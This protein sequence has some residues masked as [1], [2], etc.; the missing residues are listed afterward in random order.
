MEFDGGDNSKSSFLEKEEK[1]GSAFLSELRLKVPSLM[2]RDPKEGSD[3]LLL[4]KIGFEY[5]GPIKNQ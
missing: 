4:Q 3:L 2:G 5:P 1:E